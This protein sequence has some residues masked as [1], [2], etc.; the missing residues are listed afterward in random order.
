MRDEG[1]EVKDCE[2]RCVGSFCLTK[3]G[4]GKGKGKR[5][6]SFGYQFDAVLF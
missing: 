1:Y 2:G 3:T 5:T 4:E 6:V